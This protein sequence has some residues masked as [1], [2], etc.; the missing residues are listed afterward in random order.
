M[1]GGAGGGRIGK[2]GATKTAFDGDAFNFFAAEW[3]EFG[4]FTHYILHLIG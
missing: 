2:H 3:A 4:F 1:E